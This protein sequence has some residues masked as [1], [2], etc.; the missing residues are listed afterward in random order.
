MLQPTRSL[1]LMPQ[2]VGVAY[3]TA[4]QITWF[5]GGE[6][7]PAAP[8]EPP[9]PP[10]P[11]SPPP[12]PPAAPPPL[13]PLPPSPPPPSPSPSPPPNPPPPMPPSPSP[14]PPAPPPFPP[15]PPPDFVHVAVSVVATQAAQASDGIMRSALVLL[16]LFL[17][18]GIVLQLVWPCVAT[19]HRGAKLR[20]FELDDFG[21]PRRK[22][23]W[24]VPDS[25]ESPAADIV[26]VQEGVALHRASTAPEGQNS[27]GRVT[28]AL[29]VR[30]W[31][32]AA[33]TDSGKRTEEEEEFVRV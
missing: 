1:P 13:P 3:S 31:S 21:S 11:P 32:V 17:F 28:S 33:A 18:A 15:P 19:P 30:R 27:S 26:I 24:N 8:P 9:S 14:P 6:S 4:R 23:A 2:P 10:L 16:L 20:A 5:W 12:L 25:P 7:A 29:S 22:R